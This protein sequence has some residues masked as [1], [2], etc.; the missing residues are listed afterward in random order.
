M[1]HDLLRRSPRLTICSPLFFKVQSFIFI[2]TL[3]LP[4]TFLR[5]SFYV[6]IFY[7]QLFYESFL[8]ST[9]LRTV[10]TI[11]LFRSIVSN[12]GTCGRYDIDFFTSPRFTPGMF[13][14]HPYP[15]H[16]LVLPP[17]YPW[18]VPSPPVPAASL[19]SPPHLPLRCYSAANL[20]AILPADWALHLGF[21]TAMFQVH[22]RSIESGRGH[23]VCGGFATL[24]SAR[25]G[26]HFSSEF[27]VPSGTKEENEKC[28][29]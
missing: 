12:A 28:M 8:R 24:K 1:C 11:Q 25:S 23:N 14:R 9:F 7:V 21:S 13:P 19:G 20:S 10:F 17:I 18:D 15:L 5:F 26:G 29:V 27:V 16:P 6:F 3:P 4:L 2:I 22:E